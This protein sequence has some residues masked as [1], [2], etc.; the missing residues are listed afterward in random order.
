ML[1]HRWMWALTSAMIA[2]AGSVLDIEAKEWCEV[3]QVGAH[4]TRAPMAAALPTHAQLAYITCSSP[5]SMH[6]F[7]VA[8]IVRNEV[9][10]TAY[11]A[12][13][14]TLFGEAVWAVEI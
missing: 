7:F 4:H 8:D 6:Y 5:F 1:I 10:T 13:G 12:N 14:L 3:V 2:K 9:K 11:D